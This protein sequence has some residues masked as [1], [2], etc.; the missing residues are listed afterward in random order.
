MLIPQ[1][2][3]EWPL[4]GQYIGVEIEIENYSNGQVRRLLAESPFWENKEDH[5]LRSG[6][7]LVLAEPLMGTH[8]TQAINDFFRFV[9]SYTTGPRTS[10]HIHMNMRQDTDTMESLHNLCALYYIYEDAFFRLSDPQRKW[11]SYCHPFE[12]SP[13]EPLV[14]VLRSESIET[15]SRLLNDTSSNASR[16]Y[17]LNL[18]ALMRYG[19]IEFR[20][21]PGLSDMGRLIRWIHLLMELKKA[22]TELAERDVSVL[23]MYNSPEDMAVIESLMPTF[24]SQLRSIVPDR[25]AYRRLGMIA[26]YGGADSDALRGWETNNLL[27]TFIGKAR[28]KRP[29]VKPPA[30]KVARPKTTTVRASAIPRPEVITSGATFTISELA[31]MQESSRARSRPTTPPPYLTSGGYDPSPFGEQPPVEVGLP[32]QPEGINEEQF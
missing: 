24:G 7:E 10:V 19:T 8:L 9:T 17:G 2:G 4:A 28:A 21:M 13:P 15:V 3:A 16:Y 27:A 1:P 20:H 12:D 5:S 23:S 29:E 25:Q 14:A 32:D 11:C 26:C 6:T 30:P 22:A 31:R 18:Y